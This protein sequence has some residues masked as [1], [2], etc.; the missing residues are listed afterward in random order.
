VGLFVTESLRNVQFAGES[1]YSQCGF[2]FPGGQNSNVLTRRAEPSLPS[3]IKA[4][5]NGWLCI[6]A[7]LDK[8]F[9]CLSNDFGRRGLE[10]DGAKIVQIT[11]Q[12]LPQVEPE[13]F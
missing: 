1:R 9:Q 5:P 7:I 12:W 11:R 10:V 2:L 4:L 13:T 8:L 6:Q 3:F